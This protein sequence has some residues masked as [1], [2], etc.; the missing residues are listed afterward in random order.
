MKLFVQ[1]LLLALFILCE[2]PVLS[3]SFNDYGP[4]WNVF[5]PSLTTDGQGAGISTYDYNE[6]GWDDLSL[7]FENDTQMIYLNNQGVLE[8]SNI[9][10]YLSGEV[11]HLLWVDYDNDGDNDL[12]LTRANGNNVLLQNDGNFQFSDVTLSAGLSTAIAENYGASFADYDLDGDLDLYVCKYQAQGDST[13]LVNQNN[14]YRNNGDGTFTDVTFSAGLGSTLAPSFQGLWYDWNSD[15]YPELFVINDRSAWLNEFYLNN[16]DGSFT[17][18]SDSI[19]LSMPNSEPMSISLADYDNDKDFD[20]FV[21]DAGQAGFP[22]GSL[23]TAAGDLSYTD[24]A[25]SLG[26]GIEGNMWGS[27][28][29][30]YNNDSWQ[31]LFVATSAPFGGNT[32]YVNNAGGVFTEDTSALIGEYNTISFSTASA[33]FNR[34]GFPDLV[35]VN[36][37][38]PYVFLWVNDGN[39]NNHF[40]QISVEGTQSNRNAIGTLI[41]V[42]EGSNVYSK[43]TLCGENYLGQNAQNYLFGLGGATLVDS[44]QLYFPSGTLNTYYNLNADTSYRFVENVVMSFDL[45]LTN[46][47][48]LCEGSELLITAPNFASYTWSTGDTSSSL[49]VDETGSYA[50]YATDGQG[51]MYQSNEVYVE[52]AQQPLVNTSISA[53]TCFGEDDGSILVDII[54]AFGDYILMWN[55]GVQGDTISNLS[56]GVYSFVYQDSLGCSI[57]DTLI[58]EEPAG[59]NVQYLIRNETPDSL[60]GVE[61]LINGGTPPYT[62]YLNDSIV[63]TTVDMLTAGIYALEVIDV[64]NCGY[65]KLLEVIYEDS[66]VSSILPIEEAALS[67]YPNSFE[68]SF[69]IENLSGKPRQVKLDIFNVYGKNMTSGTYSLD[70]FSSTSIDASS[71]PSGIYLLRAEVETQKIH[72]ILI[73]R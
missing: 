56:A 1:H 9:S 43:Y 61:I 69:L 59:L 21:S 42:Y 25:T 5:T 12:F 28:W 44:I 11:K 26:V 4:I 49:L 53:I 62:I 15:T 38:S 41:K 58:V 2:S 37:L 57:Q 54:G 14:L 63:N 27:T 32:F 52:F 47:T 60:G 31:D 66:T 46:D 67:I 45:S 70:A 29:L 39:S 8:P 73:K 17:R 51:G 30:D 64:L 16:Q 3:Q 36:A 34:D 19:G 35:V 10:F 7:V 65:A 24:E 48:V 50:L 72:H 20:L 68:S 33:D 22:K 6:D 55:N 13:N 23:H 18:I 71:W 40:I